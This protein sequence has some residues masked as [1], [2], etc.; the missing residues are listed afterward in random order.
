MSDGHIDIIYMIYLN[1]KYFS[2]VFLSIYYEKP[3]FEAQFKISYS[4]FLYIQHVVTRNKFTS[5]RPWKQKNLT[6]LNVKKKLYTNLLRT[7]IFSLVNKN[8]YYIVILFLWHAFLLV[9]NGFLFP[10]LY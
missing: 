2:V 7:I 9:S 8:Y 10:L 3:V 1:V 6:L 4:C 5:F